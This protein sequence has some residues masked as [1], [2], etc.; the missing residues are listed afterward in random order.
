[1][2]S[3]CLGV[4]GCKFPQMI[5]RHL[6][7][8]V[9]REVKMVGDKVALPPSPILFLSSPLPLFLKASVINQLIWAR[10]PV[11]QARIVL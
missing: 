6:E 7:R 3:P 8:N 4:K 2:K 1:M 5:H 9:G 11:S 10:M